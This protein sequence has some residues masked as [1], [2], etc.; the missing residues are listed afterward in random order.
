MSRCQISPIPLSIITIV[1]LLPLF[2]PGV[3]THSH[4]MFERRRTFAPPRRR[5]TCLWRGEKPGPPACV[6]ML[7]STATAC[8]RFPEACL[9]SCTKQANTSSRADIWAAL[10]RVTVGS[11]CSRVQPSEPSNSGRPLAQISTP[12]HPVH[13]PEARTQFSAGVACS[14]LALYFPTSRRRTMLVRLRAAASL[15]II[16]RSKARDGGASRDIFG[17]LLVL[18]HLASNRTSGASHCVGAGRAHTWGQFV[19]S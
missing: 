2:S 4:L 15:T 7:N 1:N 16:A 11:T 9:Q 14:G 10:I 6:S 18:S 3:S 5:A 19:R 13:R 17:H 12:G 8:L